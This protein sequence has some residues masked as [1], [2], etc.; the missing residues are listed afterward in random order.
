MLAFS[1]KSAWLSFPSGKSPSRQIRKSALPTGFSTWSRK[2]GPHA[3]RWARAGRHLHRRDVCPGGIPR[4]PSP[5]ACSRVRLVVQTWASSQPPS[6]FPELAD[7]AVCTARGL[8]FQAILTSRPFLPAQFQQT[9]RPPQSGSRRGAGTPAPGDGKRG[10]LL[11]RAAD[12]GLLSSR[13]PA[14]AAGLEVSI[15][16]PSG[17]PPPLAGLKSLCRGSS[18]E[19]RVS[20]SALRDSHGRSPKATSR[21]MGKSPFCMN[22]KNSL[23]TAHLCVLFGKVGGLRKWKPPSPLRYEVWSRERWNLELPWKV[24]KN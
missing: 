12:V 14:E 21:Q 15:W 2:W 18:S 9:D 16:G 19:C 7:R 1:R 20:R 3:A 10:L 4:F 5:T 13:P 24:H 23:K 22:M 11:A 8:T 6:L 17:A